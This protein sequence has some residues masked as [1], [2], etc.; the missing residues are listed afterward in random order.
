MGCVAH[1]SSNAFSRGVGAMYREKE[2]DWYERLHELENISTTIAP[3]RL[4]LEISGAM[5]DE[6][7]GEGG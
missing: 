6:L 5:L 7:T 1:E 3:F 4:Q 2:S